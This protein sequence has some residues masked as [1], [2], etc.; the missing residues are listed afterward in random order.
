MTEDS[1]SSDAR[2]PRRLMPALF[3]GVFMAALD[4]A[5][6][7]PAIPALR[8]AFGV[9]HRQAG[10]LMVVFVLC[11]LCSTALLANL[12]DRHGRR[13]VYLAG[14]SLF[15]LGSL[16]IALSPS[17]WMVLVGRAV[18]GIGAGGIIPTASAV[19]GD[20]VAA[21][22]RGRALGLIGAIY[23]MAF[24]L[25]PPLA[26]LLMLALSWH[27]I[28]LLNLPIAAVVIGLGARSLP[29]RA[30]PCAKLPLDHLGIVLVF[31]VLGGL[32]LGITRVADAFL[33]QTLWPVF[34]GAAALGLALLIAV[35]RRAAAP[36]IPLSLF[37]NRQLA[38]TYTLTTGA[39]F[40]MGSVIFLS[41]I[42]QLAHGVEPRHAGFVLLPLVLSSM[43]G[44]MGAGR[45]L[46]RLGARTL[47]L[48]GFGALALGYA[49]SAAT[50]A[51]LWFFLLASMPVGL[52]VGIVVGGALRSIAIDEAPP[53]LRGAAQG[54]IN[55]CTSVG[56]LLSAA[57]VSAVADFGGGGARGLG[58]AYLGVAAL[59][60]LM[61]PAAL[62]LRHDPGAQLKAEPAA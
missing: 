25:G 17:F 40:G 37:G 36:M 42:A 51:G 5:V 33:G 24:V 41:S 48:A 15:A 2:T 26:T 38:I 59:M 28:F 12:G 39:G 44:S 13:P 11:S 61:L 58:I 4:T 19:I 47:L 55:I 23:G 45:L 10:L 57:A 62:G 8:E 22:E 29:R 18:Q 21:R 54:M 14:V 46:N 60:L 53:A 32:V 3:I 43:L 7:A 9:D 35:E 50:A 27:W 49:A 56:T 1:R 31:L 30:A 6:I 16:L 52:G 20:A 34:L